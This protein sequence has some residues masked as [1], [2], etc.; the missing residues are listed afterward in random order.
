M[1]KNIPT[2]HVRLSSEEQHE[3]LGNHLKYRLTMLRTHLERE[4]AAKAG[5]KGEQMQ[6][7]L[8]ICAFEAGLIASRMFLQFLGLGVRHDPLRL[9]PAQDYLSFDGTTTHE[10]KVIDVGG[11]WV[12]PDTLPA[13]DADL[14]ARTID[15]ASKASA[16]LTHDSGHA[17]SPDD[18]HPV[19][20]LISRLLKVHLYD[21]VGMDMVR[22]HH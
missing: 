10:V 11:T 19:V 22:H 1:P 20:E 18:F 4:Q 2:R 13:S 3:F 17:F 7:D 16:H 14:L 5:N 9:V 15:G 6:F 21:R 12:D 8:A